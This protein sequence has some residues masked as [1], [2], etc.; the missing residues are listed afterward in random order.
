MTPSAEVVWEQTHSS[1]G[2]AGR[3]KV[4][5]WSPVLGVYRLCSLLNHK[6]AWQACLFDCPLQMERSS[7]WHRAAP[8]F[9]HTRIVPSGPVEWKAWIP[10]VFPHLHPF[11]SP[12]TH[13]PKH[14]CPS[15]P[16]FGHLLTSELPK[17]FRGEM[18]QQEDVLVSKLGCAFLQL[19][20]V[21]IFLWS[22]DRHQPALR[23]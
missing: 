15:V 9:F 5:E 19:K 13:T 20:L 16:T 17:E 11:A 7:L 23:C 2:L 12:P 22:N 6:K 18:S 4:T 1:S 14:L 10:S 21:L 8:T 3:E